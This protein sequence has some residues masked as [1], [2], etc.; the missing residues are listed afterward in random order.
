MLE[1]ATINYKVHAWILHASMRQQISPHECGS[2]NPNENRKGEIKLT[3]GW[4]ENPIGGGGGGGAIGFY[5]TCRGGSVVSA[6]RVLA[7]SKIKRT[8]S[9]QLDGSSGNT[10]RRIRV[11]QLLVYELAGTSITTRHTQWIT[12][13]NRLPRARIVP[14]CFSLL[15]FV[16]YGSYKPWTTAAYIG[17]ANRPW[18]DSH[19]NLLGLKVNTNLILVPARSQL[20]NC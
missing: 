17:A 9:R 20:G 5:C 13:T 4:R 11:T 19:H 3:I 10:T 7:L 1:Y 6:G 15:L 16:F 12:A 2:K 8:I 14:S 18:T